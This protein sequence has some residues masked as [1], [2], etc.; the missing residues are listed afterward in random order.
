M[1]QDIRNAVL[2]LKCR[3]LIL[4]RGSNGGLHNASSTMFKS[5]LGIRS[6]RGGAF[7]VKLLSNAWMVGSTAWSGPPPHL[8]VV[9]IADLWTLIVLSSRP[10]SSRLRRYSATVGAVTSKGLPLPLLSNQV[11]N[12]FHT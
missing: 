8:M 6:W 9:Q 1:P 2:K 3:A 4:S 12:P 5:H 11:Q 10:K 7:T